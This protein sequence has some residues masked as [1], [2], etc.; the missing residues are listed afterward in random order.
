MKRMIGGLLGP[1]F[2]GIVMDKACSLWNLECNHHQ[3]CW[4]YDNSAMSKN[5]FA[6]LIVFKGLQVIIYALLW[7]YHRKNEENHSYT[8][9]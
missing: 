1:I 4:Q 2:L 7:F 9:R 6:T 5:M 8:L 3:F